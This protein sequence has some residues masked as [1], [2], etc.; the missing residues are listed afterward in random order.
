[1]AV[2]WNAVPGTNLILS[3]SSEI[4]YFS[5]VQFGV[6]EVKTIPE[7]DAV[8]NKSSKSTKSSAASGSGSSDSSDDSSSS[9]GSSSDSGKFHTFLQFLSYCLRFWLKTSC[10]KTTIETSQSRCYWWFCRWWSNYFESSYERKVSIKN[11]KE[12][13]TWFF[14][15]HCDKIAFRELEDGREWRTETCSC[16]DNTETCLP[17]II[18]CVLGGTIVEVSQIPT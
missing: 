15:G 9:S 17:G 18:P 8:S 2:Y 7:V 1:M 12:S 13:L 11:T 14:G 16:F 10:N 5:T 4:N 3:Q 6:N